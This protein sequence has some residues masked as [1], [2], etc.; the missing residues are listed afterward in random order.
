M[1]SI[2][3][4][5]RVPALLVAVTVVVGA[6]VA[7][8]A[9]PGKGFIR[10]CYAAN[11][12]LRIV[13]SASSC[14]GKERPLS[15]GVRGPAG[16][17]GVAGPQGPKGE[18][19]PQGAN[20]QKGEQGPRGQVG[21]QGA[22]GSQGPAGP[23]GARGAS[24]VLGFG[25]VGADGGV[26][27]SRSSPGAKV[28]WDVAKVSGNGYCVRG[29]VGFRVALVMPVNHND[30]LDDP[31]LAPDVRHSYGGEDRACNGVSGTQSLYVVFRDDD[32]ITLQDR[33]ATAFEIVFY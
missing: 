4:A 28:E 12:Q 32:T 26:V 18:T 27:V 23:A 17:Q 11:G 8:A 6:G 15:W 20:G 10:A 5:R 22:T 30:W 16:P 31:L 21:L 13:G 3:R 14:K 2:V 1:R 33:I 7:Y 25:F 19:G 29:P 9:T 24:G